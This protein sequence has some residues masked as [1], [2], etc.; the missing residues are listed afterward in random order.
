MKQSRSEFIDLRGVRH[1]VRRWGDPDAP[2]LF[3][4]HGWQDMSATYQAVV[5][6]F[7]ADFNI[8]APD[9]RGFGLSDWGT[10]PY[11]LTEYVL[12]LDE[13]LDLYSPDRPAAIVAHSMGGNVTGLYAGS[14]PERVAKFVN[15]EGF[16]PVPGF[17]ADSV[18]EFLGQLAEA[19]ARRTGPLHLSRPGRGGQIHRPPVPPAIRWRDRL[20]DH[21]S[22]PA[23]SRWPLGTERRSALALRPRH[24]VVD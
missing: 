14:R 13:I 12:G 8:I 18:P 24:A 17:G 9:W 1:H 16:A 10:D 4:L 23:A 21:P 2:A 20:P 5:D 11:Y 3:M 19:P 7:T 15:I 6:R 22:D